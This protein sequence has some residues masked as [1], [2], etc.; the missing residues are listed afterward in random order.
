MYSKGQNNNWSG[1]LFPYNRLTKYCPPTLSIIGTIDPI[2]P[3]LKVYELKSELSKVKVRNDV[4]ELVGASHNPIEIPISTT[5][6]RF[7]ND[8]HDKN[9]N[10]MLTN[11]NKKF[12]SISN[13]KRQ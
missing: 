3:L 9:F 4:I 8:M 12:S 6:F 11:I 7:D 10:Y 1:T 13:V 5:T 2:V